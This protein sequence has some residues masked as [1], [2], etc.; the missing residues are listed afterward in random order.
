MSMNRQFD[1]GF[2]A[3]QLIKKVNTYKLFLSGIA[4]ATNQLLTDSNYAHGVN[5][6]LATLGQATEVDRVYIFETHYHTET[7]APLMSQRWEWVAEGITPE[8]D[9]PD[10]QNLPFNDFFPRWYQS[11]I[12][13]FPISGLVSTFPKAER[14]ILEPQHI[15]SI[16]VVPITIHGKLW[17]FIGFDDC[18]RQRLWSEVEVSTLW[19]IAGTFGGVFARH[20]AE[21]SLHQ[22]NQVLETRITDRTQALTQANQELSVT[23]KQLQQTQSQLIQAEK[24]SSLG[25][26]VAGIAHELNNPISFIYGNLH[27]V[28]DY[29]QDLIY[30][31][32]GY[33][34]DYSHPSEQLQQRLNQ[35]D[36]ALIRQDSHCLLKSMKAGT[37]RIAD[38]V[39]SLRTFS[40]LDESACKR[41]DIH[42][43]ID[44]AL[45]MLNHRLVGRDNYADIE[46]I[47]RY[48]QLPLVKCFPG[49]LNQ[50][51]M[52]ILV[53]AVDAIEGAFSD[54][55]MVQPVPKI[56]I[57][58]VL[59]SAQ[60]AQ[61]RIIDNGLAN[62]VEHGVKIFDPFFTTKPV[63][64]GT[65]MGLAMSHQI[66]VNQHRGRLEHYHTSDEKTVFT[67]E[68]PVGS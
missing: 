33:Q 18:H 4:K 11:F 13:N 63:G 36:F 62:C 35:V 37:K 1:T 27:H 59:T 21:E 7:Q 12:H 38:L 26:L 15:L 51:V 5:T 55:S 43:G 46:V 53:N 39:R 54:E 42:E 6:A 19:A 20:Q 8:I 48:S 24:M 44:S 57:E 32:E 52:A 66:I 61:I 17:G 3:Q 56:E 25:Q 49:T 67:I 41:V 68:I 65:G 22:L 9:N 29:V 10:L 64:G 40:R 47:K 50:A 28:A 2:V 16:V 30:L 60:M 45:V 34:Q 23:L 14:E 58:T 31:V